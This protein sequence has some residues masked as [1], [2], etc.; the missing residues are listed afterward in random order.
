MM[1]THAYRVPNYLHTMGIVSPAHTPRFT[2]E[3][4]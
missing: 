2:H 1:G 4:V 3:A